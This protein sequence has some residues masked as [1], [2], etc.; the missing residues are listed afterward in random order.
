[1]VWKGRQGMLHITIYKNVGK[2]LRSHIS[3]VLWEFTR[4]A[5]Y[6]KWKNQGRLRGRDRS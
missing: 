2:G 6:F 1:M 5:N 4:Y 3:A